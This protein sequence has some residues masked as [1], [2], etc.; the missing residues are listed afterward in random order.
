MNPISNCPT[1][2]A[3]IA[4]VRK[5]ILCFLLVLFAHA[6]FAQPSISSFSPASGPVGTSVTINGTGFNATAANNIVYFGPVK[7]T[8]T[9]ATATSLVVTVPASAGHQ[10][11]SVTANNLTGY[12]AKPFTLSLPGMDPL[13]ADALTRSTSR[14]AYYQTWHIE[15]NALAPVDLNADGKPEIVAT[16]NWSNSMNLFTNIGARTRIS[17]STTMPYDMGAEARD[18]I[19][20]DINSDGIPEV[21]VAK[22]QT[23]YVTIYNNSLSEIYSSS[24]RGGP[25]S[26]AIADMDGDGRSDIVVGCDRSSSIVIFR[27]TSSGGTLSFSKQSI[28]LSGFMAKLAVRDIDGDGKPDICGIIP[29]RNTVV[30]LRNTYTSGNLS[31]STTTYPTGTAPGHVQCDDLDGDD[32]PE[33]VVTNTG[34]GSMSVFRNT[35]TA[36]SIGFDAKVDFTVNGTPAGIGIGDIDGDAKPEIVIGNATTASTFGGSVDVFRNNSTTGAIIFSGVTFTT[37]LT[38][39][40]I[41]I[42]DFDGDGKNDVAMG[43]LRANAIEVLRNVIGEPEITS[44]TPTEGNGTTTVTITGKNFTN[45]TDVR[46]GTIPA[47]SFVVNSST[48]I[49]AIPAATGG[50][51]YVTVTTPYGTA[52]SLGLFNFLT[53]PTITSF[54]PTSGRTGFTVTIT[55]TNFRNVLEVTLGGVRAVVQYTNPGATVMQVSVGAGASG[56]VV[57]RTSD[58]TATKAGFTYYAPPT[59]T[60]FT[61]TSGHPG[62]IITIIGTNFSNL[63]RVTFG[64]FVAPY[65]TIVSPT[66]IE[67]TVG[68]GATGDVQVRTDGG[69]ATI[70]GFTWLPPAP[71]ITSFTPT[72]GASGDVITITGSNF[73][74]V[75]GVSFGGIAATSFIV[76]NPTTITATIATGAT[77]DV[78][79]TGPGGTGT[80]ARFTFIPPAPTITGISPAA[81]RTGETVTITGTSFTNT[82]VVSFGGTAAASFTVVSPTTITAVVGT[83]NSGNVLVTTPGGIATFNGFTFITPPPPPV[84]PVPLISAI[85]PSI[86]GQGEVVTI[87]GSN[88]NNAT[89]VSFGGSPAVSFIV[90]SPTTIT[91]IVGLGNSGDVSVT[92]PNGTAVF[93]GFTYRYQV[94]EQPNDMTIYPNPA[95]SR[96]MIWVKH[97]VSPGGAWI[98]IYDMTGS[99]VKTVRVPAGEFLTQIYV[100]DLKAGYYEVALLGTINKRNKTLMVR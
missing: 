7:A 17:F 60:S 24:V 22:E 12:S 52:S 91:A 77:G 21:V 39:D 5:G 64:G 62:D 8:V 31:F 58:G 67:A 72:S 23:D 99:V 63:Q 98:N 59:I 54:T 15:K 78:S 26:L 32:K 25:N 10:P 16:Q 28:S 87:T 36:A 89:A 55:G 40:C 73:T 44:F 3:C 9:A 75:T 84:A 35:S 49:T 96:S 97:P 86:A 80:M 47:A 65:S 27:N 90:V 69:T 74:G 71:T 2:S 76:V 48:S 66:T 6:A 61:P 82:S 53:P 85:S 56:D 11:F 38:S 79:V 4:I 68:I 42:N 70:S 30:I 33:I 19:G 14:G 83:G 94:L 92:T 43:S 37:G 13:N 95:T 50:D 81:A 57:V 29:D 41:V 51:G 18:V 100:G 46:F 1:L 34:S 20:G 93:A 45:A 88:F